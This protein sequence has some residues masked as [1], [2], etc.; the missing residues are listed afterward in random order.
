MKYIYI[1]GKKI[2]VSEEVYKIYRSAERREKYLKENDIAHGAVSIETLFHEIPA[3]RNAEEE[4]ERSETHKALWNA[5]DMLT[6]KEFELIDL[7][8]FEGLSIM[9]VAEM[10]NVN[11]HKIWHERDK[12]LKKLRKI[13][14]EID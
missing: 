13:I 4:Y 7:L 6:D 9:D 10:W 1:G 8:F 11:Y 3:K 12:I 5:L 2:F 14:G